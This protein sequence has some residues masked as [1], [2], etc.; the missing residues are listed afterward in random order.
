MLG[1]GARL[2]YQKRIVPGSVVRWLLNVDAAPVAGK[3]YVWIDASTWD[4]T[5]VWKD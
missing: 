3:V 5:Q 4:D 1:M 2:I